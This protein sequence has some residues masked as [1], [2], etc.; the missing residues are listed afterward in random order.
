LHWWRSGWLVWCGGWPLSWDSS[1]SWSDWL[2]VCGSDTT[3]QTEKTRL[4]RPGTRISRSTVW[5]VLCM[6]HPCSMSCSPLPPLIPPPLPGLPLHPHL[7]QPQPINQ[8]IHTRPL[9]NHTRHPPA[10]RHPPRLYPRRRHMSSLLLML[11]TV[12]I[13]TIQLRRPLHHIRSPFRTRNRSATRPS[14]RCETSTCRCWIAGV[15]TGD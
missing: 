6:F 9:L 7:Q 15:G 4:T 2:V 8:C 12:Q 13:R 3:E 14:C 10:S 1:W 5:F 11:P